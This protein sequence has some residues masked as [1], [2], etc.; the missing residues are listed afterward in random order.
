MLRFKVSVEDLL[1]SRFALSPAL[2]LCLLLRSLAGHDRP[3][4]RA[5][6]SRLRP[7]FERLRRETELDAAL[8]L[9][10]PRGGPNFVAPPPRGLNQT[11]ADDLAMIRATPLEAARREFAA[12]ATG[13]SAREPRVRAVLESPDAVARIAEAM[14]QAWH[15]LLAADWPQLRAICERDVVH[16]VGV[17]GEHGWATAIESLH[18]SI[19]WH[20]GGI[21]IGHF[22]QVGTVHLAGD[23]L[24]L[25][26]SVFVGN[27]AAHLE[28]PWPRTLVYRARGTAALWDEQE[29]VPQ[30]DALTTLVGR[31]RARLLL[32]LDAPASTSQ[33]ARSLAMAPGA[34]GDHLAILRGA[35][36]LVRA[37]SGRSVLYR[38]TPLGEALVAGSG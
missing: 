13:P 21:E 28:D 17:I 9:Q 4:P 14:D 12:T 34:V 2:D 7:A 5:W 11:W 33:L 16:R 27:I 32:A 19:A 35:G 1:R 23:G 20:A 31:S 24:L 38:R 25:I 6:A 18:P 3:L 30:P 26:P 8:A 10:A 37:R 15:E 36:L 22:P 29:T